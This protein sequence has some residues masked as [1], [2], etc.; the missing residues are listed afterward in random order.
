MKT[1]DAAVYESPSAVVIEITTEGVLCQ[2]ALENV[3]P[4]EGEW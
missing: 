3:T 1:K 2:S 4:E